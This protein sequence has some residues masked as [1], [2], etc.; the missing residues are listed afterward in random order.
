[1][2]KN[3]KIQHKSIFILSLISLI[4]FGI[5]AVLVINQKT[6]T[7][8]SKVIAFIQGLESP[9]LTTIMKFFTTIGSTKTVAILCLIIMCVLYKVLKQRSECLLFITAIL[10]TNVLFISLKFLIQRERPSLHR[11]IEETGYSFPSGH[12][13]IA[14]ALYATVLFLLWRH[15]R[16]QW[17]RVILTVLVSMMII[18]IGISRIYVGV[19]YPSDVLAGFLIAAFWITLVIGIHQKYQENASNKNLLLK[20]KSNKVS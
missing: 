13:T 15:V 1:M 8:D 3:L 17:K 7:F 5:M 10:G 2:T 14:F 6:A 9:F 12:S 20:M 4:C 19:H 11:L 16:V 18:S